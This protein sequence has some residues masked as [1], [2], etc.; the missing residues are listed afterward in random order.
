MSSLLETYANC[1]YYMREQ[2]YFAECIEK[3]NDIMARGNLI[4]V[5]YRNDEKE[6]LIYP[7]DVR[8]DEWSSYNYLIGT[9]ITDT[10]HSGK[11]KLVNLRISYISSY[12]AVPLK[13]SHPPRCY[14]QDEIEERIAACGIQF[15]DEE[16]ATIKV[17]LPKGQGNGKDMY[18]HMVF[19]R[20]VISEMPVDPDDDIYTFRCTEKQAEYYFFKFGAKV[21]IIEPE[22]LRNLFLSSYKEAY[23]LYNK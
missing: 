7:Y 17:R 15:I 8:T 23:T 5:R 11:G 19:M 4:S 9:D 22:S 21:E 6:M 12:K 1:A 10:D 14:S 18:D 20:P 3:I 16:P 2:L 13:S